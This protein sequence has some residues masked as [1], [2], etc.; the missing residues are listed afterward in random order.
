MAQDNPQTLVSAPI[1]ADVVIAPFVFDDAGVVTAALQSLLDSQAAVTLHAGGEAVLGWLSAVDA[2]AR[3]FVF[4][5]AAPVTL[6]PGTLLFVATLHGVK[7]Q[8]ACDW[9]AAS[10][11]QSCLPIAMPPS[12]IKLQRRRYSRQ[13]APLGLPFRA[14]FKI[15]SRAYELGVDDLALG[16]VGLRASPREAALLAPGRRLPR[17]TLVFGSDERCVVDLEVCSRRDWNSYLL[18]PQAHI[19]CRFVKLSSAAEDLLCLAL[20]R[21]T[22]Q[23][24]SGR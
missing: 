16:G 18:G 24:S 20:G 17:V 4:E 9:P 10:A 12:V 19:G 11:A 15:F 8:F 21:L 23:R 1:G 7:L 13:D 14:E 5:T 2:T 6:A 22:R 3:R